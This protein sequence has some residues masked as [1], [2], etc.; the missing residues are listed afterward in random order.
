MGFS[1]D[2]KAFAE[3]AKVD[4]EEFVLAL[5]FKLNDLVIKRTPVDEGRARGG[6]IA[7]TGSPATGQ[8]S[9]DKTGNSTL[10]AANDV[11]AGAIGVVYRLTNNVEYIA[12]LEFGG[13]P[14]PVK[15]G[16]YDKRTKQYEIRSKGGFSKQAPAGMVRVSVQELKNEVERI[17]RGIGGS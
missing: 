4:H 3:K 13:Y 8:G 17:A 14:D 10:S 5:L 7:S 16:T 2:I 1:E 9:A 12:V 6:W 11:A 15:L